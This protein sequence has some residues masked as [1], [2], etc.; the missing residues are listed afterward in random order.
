MTAFM[1]IADA[2]LKQRERQL[3]AVCAH[4]AAVQVVEEFRAP[5][6]VLNPD[7][8]D[9]RSRRRWTMGI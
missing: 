8:Y 2:G 7:V 6:G 4:E 1:H 9:P 3:I 5:A